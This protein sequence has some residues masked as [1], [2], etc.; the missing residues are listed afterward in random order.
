MV[1]EFRGTG[2]L[3]SK[4]PRPDDSIVSAE[5]AFLDAIAITQLPKTHLY[6]LY[7]AIVDRVFAL[8]AARL[9]G[10]YMLKDAVEQREE[11]RRRLAEYRGI[12]GRI[13]QLRAELTKEG[14]FN[15]QVE[16]NTQ[17]KG[18]ENSLKGLSAD[19]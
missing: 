8:E 17:I 18:L 5:Q 3:V 12:E 14:Q 1:E 9:T 15:R 7:S 16:S 6:A 11:R 2:W 4:E 13:T 19:L 10:T